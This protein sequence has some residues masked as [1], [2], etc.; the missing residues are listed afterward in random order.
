[1]ARFLIHL[2]LPGSPGT[3][4]DIKKDQ[5]GNVQTVAAQSRACNGLPSKITQLKCSPPLPTFRFAGA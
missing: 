3:R 5:N 1:M 4:D 2:P